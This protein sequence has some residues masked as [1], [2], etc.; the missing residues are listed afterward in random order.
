MT[1]SAMPVWANYGGENPD[2][3]EV[4]I[5]QDF[6]TASL[7][8]TV[9]DEWDVKDYLYYTWDSYDWDY[10]LSKVSV[11]KGVITAKSSG[12]TTVTATH[13]YQVVAF[14]IGIEAAEES[15]T[16][17][18]SV[19]VGV[20]GETGLGQYVELGTSEYSWSSNDSSIASV[21]RGGALTGNSKGSTKVYANRTKGTSYVFNV[22]VEGSGSS[23]TSEKS[24]TYTVGDINYLASYV[25]N[26][27]SDYKWTSSDYNVADV[28][29]NGKI[30][31]AKAGK[32]TV[33]ATPAEVGTE[34]VFYIT[35]KGNSAETR[36]VTMYVDDTKDLSG[37]VSGSASNYS[38]SSSDKNVATVSS[39]GKVT[40]KKKGS[41]E[42]TV[43]KSGSEAYIFYITVKNS[44]SSSSS[45]SSSYNEKYTIYMGRDDSVDIS[46]YLAKS[47]SN[48]DWE[49]SDKEVC[50]V[51]GSKIK[52]VD[53]G[54]ATVKALGSKNYQFNVK[55]NKNYSN[56]AVSLKVDGTLD[57]EK[58]LDDA[59]SK[60]NISYYETGI[61]I[62]R[63][64]V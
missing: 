29:G 62:G 53:S 21:T 41:A 32:A 10:D 17:Y 30:V 5:E 38:W 13:D 55:V 16:E 60:Y 47:A 43:Y 63:A 52:A 36:N 15:N 9:G 19:T 27:A 12:Y 64:H 18:V 58:Y 50:K 59:V 33:K 54:S 11:K 14:K 26:D 24:F 42:I 23:K 49:T 4:Y 3:E 34:Y 57:L 22:T 56:Y 40:A 20:G 25:G 51:S 45:S 46:D 2:D 6:D 1:M 28:T 31:A 35:V 7:E 61:E 44:S 37:Y 39:G 8:M 48:Y